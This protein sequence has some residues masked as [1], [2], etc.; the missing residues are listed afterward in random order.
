[1]TYTEA[2]KLVENI[3]FKSTDKDNMEF[4][5]IVSCFQKDALK[6]VLEAANI[7]NELRN[8]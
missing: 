4:I 2:I 3:K 6:E 7:Y 5:A 1:L 8:S